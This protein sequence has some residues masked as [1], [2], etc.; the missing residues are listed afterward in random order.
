MVPGERQLLLWLLIVLNLTDQW[1]FMVQ[2][3]GRLTEPHLQNNIL[4]SVTRFCLN[5][6]IN[7]L[8]CE[9][10]HGS[11]AEMHFSKAWF[12]RAEVTGC[13]NYKYLGHYGILI[14]LAV[15]VCIITN[16]WN[17]VMGFWVRRAKVASVASSGH[18][19]KNLGGATAHEK[20]Q[21]NKA[22]IT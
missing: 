11:L 19:W 15:F 6:T 10:Q 7:W 4:L 5:L 21:A 17:S 2:S 8:K 14:M 16:S 22:N 13:S 3:V 12:Y 20:K 9:S 18:P 1:A